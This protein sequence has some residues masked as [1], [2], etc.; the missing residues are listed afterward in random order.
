MGLLERALQY[1]QKLND[2][3]KDT[4]IDRIKGP[5]ETGKSLNVERIDIKEIDI[6]EEPVK[7]QKPVFIEDIV[8][9]ESNEKSKS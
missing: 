7:N 9:I 1:K 6:I 4:L 3:G 2:S 8:I 5:A